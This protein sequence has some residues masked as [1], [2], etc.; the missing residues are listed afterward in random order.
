LAVTAVVLVEFFLLWLS[1]CAVVYYLGDLTWLLLM[2][3]LLVCI[4][5]VS[6]VVKRMQPKLLHF[7]ETVPFTGDHAPVLELGV[8]SVKMRFY[9]AVDLSLMITF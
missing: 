9:S 7:S 3:I 5:V 2:S 8:H 1:S 4:Q 6:N